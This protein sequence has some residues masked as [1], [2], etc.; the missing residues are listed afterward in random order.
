MSFD[1]IPK[2]NAY[3]KFILLHSLLPY[4]S[5]A[6]NNRVTVT[7]TEVNRATGLKSLNGIQCDFVDIIKWSSVA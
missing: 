5:T 2:G 3:V 6:G 7:C 1:Y 4:K